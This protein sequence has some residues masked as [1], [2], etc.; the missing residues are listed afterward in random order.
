MINKSNLESAHRWWLANK[1]SLVLQVAVVD[2]NQTCGEQCKAQLDDEFGEG[3]SIF[4]SC[5]V[6]DGVALKGNTGVRT[7]TLCFW[8]RLRDEVRQT[9]VALYTLQIRTTEKRKE[10]AWKN[11][12]FSTGLASACI[13][14]FCRPEVTRLAQ[15]CTEVVRVYS[16]SLGNP[17]LLH[18]DLTL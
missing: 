16:S 13:C 11:N 5:D 2:L 3:Q 17:L 15:S 8:G 7:A 6:T 1:W 9:H 4:I 14:H 18:L 12:R 10:R